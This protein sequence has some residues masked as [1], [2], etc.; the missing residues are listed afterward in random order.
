MRPI[1]FI[2][3][4]DCF[5]T[6]VFPCHV[7]SLWN[8]VRN[9]QGSQLAKL[10]LSKIVSNMGMT[11][12]FKFGL[13]KWEVCPVHT[14]AFSFEN[15]YI[16][17]RLGLPSKLIRRAF[18]SKPHRFENALESGSERKSIH[19]LLVW[20]VK[21]GRK[22]IKEKTITENIAGACVYSMPI[23]CNVHHNVPILSFSKVLVWTVEN[24]SKRYLVW[25]QNDRQFSMK[26]KTY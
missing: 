10:A 18:S 26:T 2:G 5:W 11:E 17:I 15:A 21:N 16:S 8:R 19:I 23:E 7:S 4:F 9:G 20:T 24:A 6:A 25:T 14:N 22:H 13:K 1:L 3:W 12:D